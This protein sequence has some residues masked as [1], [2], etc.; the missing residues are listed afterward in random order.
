MLHSVVHLS[1]V[2]DIVLN[3]TVF[4]PLTKMLIYI[5]QMEHNND[6]KVLYWYL[7]VWRCSKNHSISSKQYATFMSSHVCFLYTV[8]RMHYCIK[9]VLHF[10]VLFTV[11]VIGVMW[12]C[13]YH[14][15]NCYT[16]PILFFKIE[17]P[18]QRNRGT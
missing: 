17:E 11:T 2:I 10:M 1:C 5:F 13:S 18:S 8:E 3:H 12:E 14:Q 15:I 7:I 16:F 9:Q 4:F 6:Q